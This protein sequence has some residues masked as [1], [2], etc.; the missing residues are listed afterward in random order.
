MSGL[1][2]QVASEKASTWTSYF[3]LEG[4]G[5]ARVR[6]RMGKMGRSWAGPISFVGYEMDLRALANWD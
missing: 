2:P 6:E 5:V 4:V 3:V 1:V